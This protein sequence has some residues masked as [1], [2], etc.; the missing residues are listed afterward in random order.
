MDDEM[1]STR[2]VGKRIVALQ[3]RCVEA[4]AGSRGGFSEENH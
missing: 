3:V 1:S 2:E 4:D